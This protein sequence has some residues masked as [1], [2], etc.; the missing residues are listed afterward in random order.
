MAGYGWKVWLRGNHDCLTPDT[1]A[2]TR[3]GWLKHDQIQVGDEI[4][5][6][7]ASS[8]GVQWEPVQ[9]VVRRQ[10]DGDVLVREGAG[11]SFS[12]TPNHRMFGRTLFSGKSGR[13]Y[14][15]THA[16]ALPGRFQIPVSARTCNQVEYGLTDD[17]IRLA[18]WMLTDS[19]HTSRGYV[20]FYQSGEASSRIRSL[21]SRMGVEFGERVRDRQVSQICGRAVSSVQVSYEFHLTA[22]SSRVWRNRLDVYG[23]ETLPA[24]VTKLSERQFEVLLDEIVFCDGTEFTNCRWVYKNKALLD[25]L[26]GVM[27]LFGWHGILKEYRDGQFYLSLNKRCQQ[28]IMQKPTREHYVGCVW[29]LTVPSGNFFIRRNGKTH[30]T[31][32]CRLATH[33]SGNA[34]QYEGVPGFALKD[35]FPTW[36]HAMRLDLNPGEDSHTIVKHRWKGG[37]HSAHNNSKDSGVNFVTGHLHA[38]KVTPWNNARGTYFGV[39]TGTLADTNGP[40][41]GYL[42]DGVTQWRSG[43]AILT[44]RHGRLLTPEVVRVI[45]EG[46]VEFRG[47]EY[48]V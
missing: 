23:H 46:V 37:V 20:V 2:L 12:V 35:H 31:G 25:A 28:D 48:V 8:G 33:L 29:C 15:Y 17:E 5:S 24:W 19:H 22:Q 21:L 30:F 6:Y 40:H 16:D 42:E 7:D 4:L 39:D 36:Q 44:F 41:A 18:A 27:P 10:H 26:Q 47:R 13:G 38:L 9:A 32:N 34:P 43:F 14:T 3:R 11:L 1:E 45:A